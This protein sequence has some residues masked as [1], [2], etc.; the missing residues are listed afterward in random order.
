[1]VPT[2]KPAPAKAKNG[3]AHVAPA[4][5]PPPR[6]KAPAD[7]G[8]YLVPT[9]KPA[10][11]SAE[12]GG[13]SLAP[14]PVQPAA[15]ADVGTGVGAA[16]IVAESHALAGNKA[17]AGAGDQ[18]TRTAPASKSSP[19]VRTAATKINI[20]ATTDG[21]AGDG[22]TAAVQETQFGVGPTPTVASAGQAPAPSGTDSSASSSSEGGGASASVLVSPHARAP[23]LSHADCVQYKRL[24]NTARAGNTHIPARATADFLRTSGINTN[25]LHKVRP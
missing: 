9:A 3:S 1:M 23:G 6:T 5:A 2:V 16:G 22:K 8:D 17:Q 13:E 25:A 7:E 4:P 20:A 15:P 18:P 11:A 12:S 19:A 10:P 21:K 14:A 24:W